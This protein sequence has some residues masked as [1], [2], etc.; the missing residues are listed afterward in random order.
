MYT[1]MNKIILCANVKG[2]VGKT[3][4]CALFANFLKG[5]DYQEVLAILQEMGF[6]NITKKPLGDLKKGWIYDDGEVKEVS[7]AGVTKFAAGDIFDKTAE[8]IVSYHSFR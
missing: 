6:T 2:G 1:T 3:C 8:I 5:K 4:L 7:I